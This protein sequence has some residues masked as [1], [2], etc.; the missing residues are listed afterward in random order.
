MQEINNSLRKQSKLDDQKRLEAEY[1]KNVKWLDP[2][3]H[4]EDS[5]SEYRLNLDRRQP[6]TSTWIFNHVEYKSW[7]QFDPSKILWISGNAGMRIILM[8]SNH[9]ISI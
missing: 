4:L 7:Y 5:G 9:Y 8:S 6:N 1:E 3:E 2:L